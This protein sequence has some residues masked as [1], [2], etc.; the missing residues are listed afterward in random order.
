MEQKSRKV[1]TFFKKFYFLK[2]MKSLKRAIESALTA[3]KMTQAQLA[4]RCKTNA[5][6]LT[7]VIQGQRPKEDLLHALCNC[8]E[9]DET[10]LLILRGHLL[11]E[12]LRSG[13]SSEYIDPVIRGDKP[14][15]RLLIHEDLAK[16]QKILD[17]EPE[18][19]GFIHRL[20]NPNP[21]ENYP[22]G[23]TPTNAAD[24]VPYN[25]IKGQM[26]SDSDFS[27]KIKNHPHRA[28]ETS[29]AESTP[30]LK[31]GK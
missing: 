13:F 29:T 27:D 10:G 20:A 19:T 23:A 28:H 11:D 31:P 15:E 24:T 4:A 5:P 26:T 25:Q 14:S 18:L 12:I 8:W 16:L 22:G 3:H 2:N 30:I 6:T 21:T 17:E 9:D 1:L 7:R